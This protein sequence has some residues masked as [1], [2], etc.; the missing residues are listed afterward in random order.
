[1]T[2]TF[3]MII[4]S[5]PILGGII[6][7]F[8]LLCKALR[9]YIGDDKRIVSGSN[10]TVE[11]KTS[12]LKASVKLIL[13]LLFII[14]SG[15]AFP[16]YNF[17]KHF[18]YALTGL[19]LWL[20]IACYIELGKFEKYILKMTNIY[21]VILANFGVI[22]LGMLCRYLLEFGEVSNTY[23]FTIQNILVHVIATLTISMV[24][25]F[26]SKNGSLN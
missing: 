4:L 7:L 2:N 1:M 17:G 24:S 16:I 18:S 26:A 6:Y 15:A 13:W 19:M 12:S 10:E 11:K 8:V 5:L 22:L 23:N 20:N 9:K 25:Y 3:I 14:I 21:Y